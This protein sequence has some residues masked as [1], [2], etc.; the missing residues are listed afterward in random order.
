MQGEA[1]STILGL[2]F[3]IGIPL[4]VVVWLSKSK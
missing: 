4:A 1:L 3:V 2:A